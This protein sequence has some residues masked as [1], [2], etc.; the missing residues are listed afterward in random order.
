MASNVAPGHEPNL[1]LDLVEAIANRHGEIDLRLDHVSLK[2]PVIREQIEV[3]GSISISVHLR[4]LTDK[5]R[6][7]SAAREIR[8]S[9]R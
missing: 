5:E 1:F 8:A 9:Q 4:E 2:L 6:T 7:A 3:N